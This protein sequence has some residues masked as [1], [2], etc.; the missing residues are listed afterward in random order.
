MNNIIYKM[1]RLDRRGTM[2]I[3]FFKKLQNF[4]LQ[5]AG[6]VI[7]F[8]CQF[9]APCDMGHKSSSDV[10]EWNRRHVTINH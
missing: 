7:Y 9:L 2:R 8:E 3:Y 4:N 1:A 6:E 10:S 5:G